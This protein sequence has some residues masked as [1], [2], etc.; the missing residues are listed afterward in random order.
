MKWILSL[1]VTSI[2]SV[3]CFGQDLSPTVQ[4]ARDQF[5]QFN[6]EVQLNKE[7]YILGEPVIVRFALRNSTR[8]PRSTY[9]PEFLKES[10]MVVRA[11]SSTK[12]HQNLTAPVGKPVRMLD[13]LDAGGMIVAEDLIAPAFVMAFFPEPGKYRIQVVLSN[14]AGDKDLKSNVI[15]VEFD[16]PVGIDGDAFEYMQRHK[17]FFG[18]SS[19][20]DNGNNGFSLLQKFAIDFEPSVYG[21]L[22][23]S[24]L[25]SI[26]AT[27]GEFESARHQL[28]KL[29]SS[30]S[31]FF[32][33]HANDRLADLDKKMKKDDTP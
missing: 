26:Y 14:T 10:K 5:D 11:R 7:R 1:L 17:D 19:W 33:K 25:A 32:S 12:I 29:Q 16:T 8:G 13:R 20:T 31:S 6:F 2:T 3:V 9:A 28:E 23:I 18:L 21:D 30:R 4:T 22:A 24:S 15:E 27:R